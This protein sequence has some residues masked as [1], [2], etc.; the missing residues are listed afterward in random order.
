MADVE[1]VRTR[2][3]TAAMVQAKDNQESDQSVTDVSAGAWKHCMWGVRVREEQRSHQVL[4]GLSDQVW[5][6]AG[7]ICPN[8]EERWLEDIKSTVWTCKWRC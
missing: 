6:D 2:V 3:E 1:T 7:D 8:G 4:P 5:C